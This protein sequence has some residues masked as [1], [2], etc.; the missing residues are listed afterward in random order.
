M[1]G[2]RL[3][4]ETSRRKYPRREEEASEADPSDDLCGIIVSSRRDEDVLSV[5][6]SF[7]ADHSMYMLIHAFTKVWNKDTHKRDRLK[8]AIVSA[9]KLNF[10]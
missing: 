5:S 10:A 8:D 3:L 4:N 2:N 9:L 1:L 7:V 6:L